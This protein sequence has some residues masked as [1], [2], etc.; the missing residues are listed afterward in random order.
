MS[1]A[2]ELPS[3]LSTVRTPG[4]FCTA[5]TIELALPLLTVQGVGAVALPLLPQQAEQLIAV[6]DRAPYGRGAQTIVDTSVRRTWQ[7]GAERVR[8]EGASWARTLR[9]IAERVAEGLG[10]T[11]AVTA[12]LYKLLVYDEGSFFIEH[13]DTEKVPGMFA[14]LV[15]ALPSIHTGGELVVRHKGREV[16]LDLH[17]PDP[18]MAAFAAF[19]ADCVH[20]VLPVTSGCRLVLVYNLVR[21]G[22]GRLPQPPDYEAETQSIAALLAAWGAGEWGPDDEAPAKL[23]YPLEHAYTPAELSFQAL[24][25][26]DAAAAAVLTAAAQRSGC[27]LHVA[28]L[29]IE[30]SG[31]A[32]YSGYSG[33]SWRD[34]EFEI[35]EVCSSSAVLSDWRSPDGT[36]AELGIFPVEDGDLCPPDMFEDMEPDKQEFQEATGNEGASFERSYR[37]AALV[38]WPKARRLEVISQAGLPV[39]L[40]WLASL[41][42]CWRDSGAP[43][44]SPLWK[45]AH[46][47]AGHMLDAWPEYGEWPRHGEAPSTAARMLAT[48]AQL[49]DAARIDAFLADISAAGDYGMSDNESLLAAASLL[50]PRRA[51]VLIERIVR[52]NA[53]K[54]PG[55]CADLLARGAAAPPPGRPA[56]DLVAAARALLD[57]LPG[58][59]ARAPQPPAN[60]WWRRQEISSDLIVDLV[61]ALERIDATLAEQAVDHLLAWP[62]TYGLDAVILPA[63]RHLTSQAATRDTPGVQR[64][65]AACVQHLRARTAEPLEPP[66]NWARAAR[67]NCRCAHCTELAGFLRNPDEPSWILKAA[68]A[69]RAHVTSIVRHC[70]CDLDLVTQRRGSPYSLVC[71]KNQASYERREK[72]RRED[73]QDLERLR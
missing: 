26:A 53:A 4:D 7:I 12:Q 32:E 9:S 71:T 65:R 22:R 55:A 14:T 63:V 17:G 61:T 43:T 36:A 28:L 72:Q 39:S 66:T 24:K 51:A 30:E 50:A 52:A 8:L 68:E 33:R 41:A 6:A 35:V 13:R 18:S 73:L 5:G 20:E 64:L 2:R 37:R 42:R 29:T 31:S 16:R 70:R 27:E 45:E 58:H 1:I 3:L 11:T 38:L 56:R 62:K 40:P 10:V 21:E 49:K 34:D 44:D 59:P 25:G 23:V 54:D 19:Y 69:V 47:L 48:L 57:A 60:A 15:V 46:E 67:L